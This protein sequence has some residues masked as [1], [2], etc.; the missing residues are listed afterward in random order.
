MLADA[1][2]PTRTRLRERLAEGD[3]LPVFVLCM[4]IAALPLINP[5][6][7]GNSS[8]VDA[9]LAP[10]VLIVLMWAA[11]VRAHIRVPYAVP[12]GILMVAG[13]VGGL[14]G[15]EPARAVVALSQE[16]FMLAFAAAIA[17]V[18]RTPGSIGVLL[19]TWAWSAIVWAT[20]LIA[21]VA[22]GLRSISGVAGIDGGRANFTFDHPN[23]AA[24]YFAMSLF[25]VVIAGRPRNGAM[26]AVAVLTLLLAVFLTGSNAA[27]IGVLSGAVVACAIWAARRFDP[28]AGLALLT[29]TC[30]A[31]AGFAYLASHT[32]AVGAV[33]RSANPY[34]R[35]SVGRGDRS[36]ESRTSLFRAEFD[37]FRAAPLIG[38][39]PASTRS[40]L[41]EAGASRVKEAH[42][43]YLAALVERGPLGFIGLLVLIGAV[44]MRSAGTAPGRLAPAFARAV[45]GTGAFAGAGVM[46]AVTAATHEVLHYRHTWALFGILAALYAWGRGP[47][48][49]AG[50]GHAS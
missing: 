23:L 31:V 13:A 27:L 1:G 16:L 35:Y 28:L 3:R 49:D 34:V 26:R 43:D 32:G 46:L 36:L 50:E 29:G 37:L 9:I 47:Q 24:S 17:T 39:G 25:V 11:G 20:I 33:D 18:A 40:A 30:L 45:P 4:S 42:N 5:K 10:A 21:S 48:N 38:R 41:E 14:A 22:L 8:P 7:P 15:N 6:G 2:F 12:L 44:A 19:A